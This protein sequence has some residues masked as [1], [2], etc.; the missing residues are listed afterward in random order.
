MHACKKKTFVLLFMQILFDAFG[1]NAN[2]RGDFC[3]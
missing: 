3:S 2:I 1:V